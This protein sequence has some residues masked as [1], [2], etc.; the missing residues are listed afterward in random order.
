MVCAGIL[1]WYP[2]DYREKNGGSA[3]LSGHL[4]M[5]EAISSLASTASHAQT[6]TYIGGIILLYCTNIF[7]QLK[8]QQATHQRKKNR[9]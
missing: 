4:A 7:K 5:N 6:R 2:L 8:S 1:T 9:K 3:K